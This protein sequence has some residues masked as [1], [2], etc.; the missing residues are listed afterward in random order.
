MMF[1]ITIIK[2]S[3]LNSRRDDTKVPMNFA[4]NRILKEPPASNMLHNL[5]IFSHFS[6]GKEIV[7]CRESNMKPKNFIV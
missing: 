6:S 7:I 4:T 2:R 3:I 5:T 1:K